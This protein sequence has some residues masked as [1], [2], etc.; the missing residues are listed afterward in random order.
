M[1]GTKIEMMWCGSC[2]KEKSVNQ[3]SMTDDQEEC[4][5]CLQDQGDMAYE[6]WKD[7]QYA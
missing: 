1:N 3:F 7:G 4:D 6:A 2:E 5:D